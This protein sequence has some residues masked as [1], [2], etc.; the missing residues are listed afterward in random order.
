MQ[1]NK[2]EI[3]TVIIDYAQLVHVYPHEVDPTFLWQ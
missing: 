1:H 3:I 2:H